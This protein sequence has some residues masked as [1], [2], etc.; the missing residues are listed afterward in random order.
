MTDRRG[1]LKE[2]AFRALPEAGTGWPS[3]TAIAHGRDEDGLRHEERCASGAH[4]ID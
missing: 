1:A 3:G 4:A 2:A